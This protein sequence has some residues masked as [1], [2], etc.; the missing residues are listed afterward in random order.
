MNE[1][2]FQFI[3]ENI[4]IKEVFSGYGI[5]LNEPR[6]IYSMITCPF[7]NCSKK[8]SNFSVNITKGIFYCFDCYSS[9][10]SIALVEKLEDKSPL[11]AAAK[12][13]SFYNIVIP[14]DLVEH[15]NGF[16]GEEFVRNN[17]AKSIVL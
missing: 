15:C 5:V 2:I 6:D 8:S 4:S 12:C 7:D 16:F 14:D 9:G 3:K 17:R 11:Q 1:N 13:L 10:D